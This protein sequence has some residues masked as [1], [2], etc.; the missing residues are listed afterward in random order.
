MIDQLMVAV[1]GPCDAVQES[2]FNK[3]YLAT[4]V[5]STIYITVTTPDMYTS[6]RK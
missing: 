3:I 2:V 6:Y 4:V 1:Q 5:L